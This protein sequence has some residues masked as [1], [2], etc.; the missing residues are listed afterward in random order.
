MSRPL[1][2]PSHDFDGQHI[3]TDADV[4]GPPSR[5]IWATR[6]IAVLLSVGCFY[7]LGRGLFRHTVASNEAEVLKATLASPVPPADVL[8]TRDDLGGL[9][10]LDVLRDWGKLNADRLA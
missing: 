7:A 8:P 1:L 10:P 9:D 5:R 3:Y 2:D 4:E 6:L